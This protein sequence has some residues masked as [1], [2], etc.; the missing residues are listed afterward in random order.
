MPEIA[1][2]SDGTFDLNIAGVSR[3]LAGVK[4]TFAACSFN[5]PML[6]LKAGTYHLLC[7]GTKRYLKVSTYIPCTNNGVQLTRR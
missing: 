4:T 1:E 6:Y 3:I 2:H 5:I 7:I